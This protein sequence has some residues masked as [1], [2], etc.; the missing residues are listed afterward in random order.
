MAANGDSRVLPRSGKRTVVQWKRSYRATSGSRSKD[1][2]ESHLTHKNKEKNTRR[3]SADTREKERS[4]CSAR[5]FRDSCARSRR[6]RRGITRNL[7]CHSKASHQDERSQL[8]D[9]CCK[10]H[11]VTAGVSG[12]DPGSQSAVGRKRL[13]GW[14]GKAVDPTRR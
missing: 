9:A 6:R 5:P 10:E 11:G 1:Q 8:H 14:V 12:P 13:V 2:L 7:G 3:F 4:R